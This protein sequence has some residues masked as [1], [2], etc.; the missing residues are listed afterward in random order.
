MIDD[1]SA[2]LGTNVAGFLTMRA[3]HVPTPHGTV[4]KDLAIPD[5]ARDRIRSWTDSVRSGQVIE[6]TGVGLFLKGPAPLR[7]QVAGATV[8]AA[9]VKGLTYFAALVP[10]AVPIRVISAA[11]YVEAVRNSI[12]DRDGD[13]A[14]LVQALR[15]GHHGRDGDV[16]NVRLAVLTDLGSEARTGVNKFAEQELQA[17]LRLRFE[18]GMPT[19]VT[20]RYASGWMAKT[21][22]H[23]MME[24]ISLAFRPVDLYQPGEEVLDDQQG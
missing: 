3:A 2:W 17:L 11:A 8:T 15:A 7:N 6:G 23:N 14:H 20:T 22:D 10:S 18:R 4:P 1:L 16:Y 24:I 13:D 21:Y 12:S 19:I 5:P 9:A